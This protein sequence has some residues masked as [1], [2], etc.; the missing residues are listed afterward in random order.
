LAEFEGL[1][2]VEVCT[3]GVEAELEPVEE[4]VS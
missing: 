1:L 4:A 2:V 3:A